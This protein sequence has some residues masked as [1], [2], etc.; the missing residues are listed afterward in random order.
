[1]REYNILVSSGLYV[2]DL[3]MVGGGVFFVYTL[4]FLHL[5]IFLDILIKS[6]I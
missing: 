3:D 1:M 4:K 5:K 6:P 2:S